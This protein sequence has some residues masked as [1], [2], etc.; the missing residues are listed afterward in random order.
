MRWRQRV[1]S[2]KM[3][4]AKNHVTG[5]QHQERQEMEGSKA[6]QTLFMYGTSFYYSW[7]APVV[8]I[9]LMCYVCVY[10]FIQYYKKKFQIQLEVIHSTI[11]P[12]LD[13]R[14][15]QSTTCLT[16]MFSILQPCTVWT[17]IPERHILHTQSHGCHVVIY[18]LCIRLLCILLEIYII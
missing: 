18:T 9:F 8:I 3:A 5:N 4:S 14:P 13:L 15:Q 12:F 10:F 2:C 11:N 7:D 16:G 1:M 6:G 17:L